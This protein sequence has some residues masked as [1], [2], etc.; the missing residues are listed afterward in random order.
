M[1]GKEERNEPPC[2]LVQ[3]EDLDVVTPGVW[4]TEVGEEDCT[5]DVVAPVAGSRETTSIPETPLLEVESDSSSS[6]DEE[7]VIQESGH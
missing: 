6:S 4:P 1:E 2:V 7:L 5:E 3:R